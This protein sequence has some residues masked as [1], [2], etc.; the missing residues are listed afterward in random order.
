MSDTQHPKFATQVI[1]AGEQ[2]DP[3]YNAIMPPVV[4]ASSFIKENIGAAQDSVTAA[5]KI[6]PG[7][8]WKPAWRNLKAAPVRSPVRQAWRRP[9]Q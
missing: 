7:M 9:L 6:Q 1:H 5:V 2:K 3:A 4:T 8:H